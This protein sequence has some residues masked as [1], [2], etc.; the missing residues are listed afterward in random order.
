VHK[1]AEPARNQSLK[2]W[3]GLFEGKLTLRLR[4]PNAGAWPRREPFD[5]L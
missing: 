3:M 2:N 1:P 4:G 5:R